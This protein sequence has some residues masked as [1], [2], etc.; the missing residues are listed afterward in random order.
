MMKDNGGQ[1]NPVIVDNSKGKSQFIFLCDHASNRIPDQYN[2]LGLNKEEL[3]THIA[4][5]PG[6]LAVAQILSKEFDAPIVRSTISRLVIDVNRSRKADD[7]IPAISENTKISGNENIDAE[8]RN[9][10]IKLYHKPYHEMINMLID[11]RQK[12]GIKSIIIAVHSFTPIY[13]N[14]PRPWPIGLIPCQDDRFSKQFF[15]TLKENNSNMNIGWNEPYAARQG[16][17]YTMHKHADLR[18]LEGSM[19]EIRNDE[20]A[21]PKGVNRWAKIIQ[22]ALLVSKNSLLYY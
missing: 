5:D 3:L 12:E 19:I 22:K 2:N 13:N 11:D 10:R 15:M 16:V 4:W 18:Q 20:I 6:S 8:E 9:K 7:L 21:D 14:I 1:I 17:F